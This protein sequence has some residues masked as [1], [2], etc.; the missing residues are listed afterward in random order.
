MLFSPKGAFK[1]THHLHLSWFPS[2]GFFK[3]RLNFTGGFMR[4]STSNTVFVAPPIGDASSSVS[5]IAVLLTTELQ[6]NILHIY[7]CSFFACLEISPSWTFL[8]RK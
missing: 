7:N 8:H 2:L 4:F 1:K 6:Q 5:V 3:R